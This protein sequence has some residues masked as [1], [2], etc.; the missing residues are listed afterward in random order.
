MKNYNLLSASPLSELHP[1]RPKKG[2]A[3]SP[4]NAK[5]KQIYLQNLEKKLDELLNAATIEKKNSS[6]NPLRPSAADMTSASNYMQYDKHKQDAKRTKK[7]A[8]CKVY[9]A[10]K[11][12][13]NGD[14]CLHAHGHKELDVEYKPLEW[15]K[16]FRQSA[17]SQGI[18]ARPMT[19]HTNKHTTFNENEY[20]EIPEVSRLQ[21]SATQSQFF[22]PRRTTQAQAIRDANVNKVVNTKGRTLLIEAA[23]TNDLQSVKALMKKGAV[24]SQKDWLGNNAMFY[25][26]RSS[27]AAILEA[28]IK[29]SLDGINLDEQFTIAKF[30]YLILAAKMGS[31]KMLEVLLKYGAKPNVADRYNKTVLFYC[32]EKNFKTGV[33]MVLNYNADVNRVDVHG[34]TALDYAYDMKYIDILD[35]LIKAGGQSDDPTKN[36]LLLLTCAEYNLQESAHELL[37]RGLSA[38]ELDA[39]GNN[40]LM[41]AYECGNLDLL[42]TVIREYSLQKALNQKNK[43]G[44]NLILRSIKDQNEDFT[45]FLM[46]NPQLELNCKDETNKTLLMYAAEL[47]DY[48]TVEYLISKGVN[49]DSIDKYGRTGLIFACKNDHPL[50]VEIILKQNINALWKD[51]LNKNAKQYASS[52]LVKGLMKHYMIEKNQLSESLIKELEHTNYNYKK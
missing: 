50:I 47:G 17:S 2:R 16:I 42:E 22:N 12:C 29:G 25:T 11:S 43:R 4:T 14:K 15:V 44:D 3:K 36:K 31:T 46:T 20:G 28:L 13:K 21:T 1:D 38:N 27:N 33:E 5:N 19:T 23:T 35:V 39:N 41:V 7:T 45:H 34:K 37:K 51:Y 32:V 18:R 26:I 8:L 10:L 40:M 9:T 6:L 24:A 48:K 49:P 30:N 52:D